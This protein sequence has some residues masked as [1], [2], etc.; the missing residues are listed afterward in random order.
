M[1]SEVKILVAISKGSELAFNDLFDHYYDMLLY[2][3]LRYLND[4]EEAKEVVQDTFVKLWENR[5][6][7]PE[8]LNIRNYLH[9]MVKNNCLNVLKKNELILKNRKE[10][11]WKEMEYRYQALERMQY[12]DVEFEE[13]R[14]KIEEAINKL[15]VHYKD[16]FKLNRFENLKYKEIAVRLNISEKTV[17]YHMSKALSL[18]RK[19][20]AQYLSIIAAITSLLD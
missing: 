7:L 18:L 11:L 3:S 20:L 5:S 6:S 1:D 9:T 16:V 4:D 2:F 10:L 15:P 19:E 17:E 14:T 12:G 8:V 13:L